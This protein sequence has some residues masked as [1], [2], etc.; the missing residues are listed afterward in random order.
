[1]MRRKI[2]MIQKVQKTGETP[3]IQF[4]DRV[5]D[6]PVIAHKRTPLGPDSED[7]GGAPVS[8]QVGPQKKKKEDDLTADRAHGSHKG[9]H[10]RNIRAIQ[11]EVE[12]MKERC[13]RQKAPSHNQGVGTA[14]APRRFQSGTNDTSTWT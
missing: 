1:M 5:T 2:S 9:Q 6:V 3:Q 7:V 13:L 8:R 11:D 14:V 10:R 12:R 4:T